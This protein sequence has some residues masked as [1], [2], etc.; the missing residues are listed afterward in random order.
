MIDCRAGSG[1]SANR[2][3]ERNH[4]IDAD[5]PCPAVAMRPGFD[6]TQDAQGNQNRGKRLPGH[7]QQTKQD[8][9]DISHGES[10]KL[11]P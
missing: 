2:K 7:P 6:N 5:Q 11:K 10:A 3:G 1:R 4:R 8:I 9:P